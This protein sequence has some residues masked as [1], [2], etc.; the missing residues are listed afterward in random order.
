[1]KTAMKAPFQPVKL[2]IRGNKSAP[3]QMAN[4]RRKSSAQTAKEGVKPA[5][6][7]RTAPAASAEWT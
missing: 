5:L 7:A 6:V 4:I 2:V 1:M 3:A